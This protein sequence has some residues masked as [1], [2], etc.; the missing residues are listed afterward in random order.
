MKLLNFENLVLLNYLVLLR[1]ICLGQLLA[2]SMSRVAMCLHDLLP[3]DEVFFSK[4]EG[5]QGEGC[6]FF[7]CR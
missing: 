7:R 5:Q 4:L 6:G 3:L 1:A 2:S